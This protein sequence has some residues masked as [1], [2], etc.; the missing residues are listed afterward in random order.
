M[1]Y[2]IITVK[3]KS[4][5]VKIIH[6]FLEKRKLQISNLLKQLYLYLNQ[7]LYLYIKTT[8]KNKTKKTTTDYKQLM[9]WIYTVQ[10]IRFLT[11]EQ[12]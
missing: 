5:W 6:F 8:K 10:S 9:N 7:F 12:R 1:Q 3:A 2:N 4:K 11:I